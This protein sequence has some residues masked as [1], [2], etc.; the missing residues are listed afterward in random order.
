[1]AEIALVVHTLDAGGGIERV[2]GDLANAWVRRNHRVTAICLGGVDRA[3]AQLDERV[4][5][6]SLEVDAGYL[7]LVMASTAE[8]R[9]RRL[10]ASAGQLRRRT[11][12]VRESLEAIDPD[13]VVAFKTVDNVV[14]ALAS[15][16]LDAVLIACEHGSP[17]AMT[18]SIVTRLA[19]K[20]AFG[21]ADAV[22]ALT[23][24]TADWIRRETRASR[25]VVIPNSVDVD[26]F[27]GPV[28]PSC[29]DAG[30]RHL[31][32][33]GR[34]HPQKGFDLLLRAFGDV[35]AAHPAWNL[36][37]VGDGPEA[38]RLA[39]LIAA[40]GLEDRVSMPGWVADP[41]SWYRSADAFVLSSRW[42]GF[43]NVVL[44]AMA[45]GLSVVSYACP[46]GPADIIDHERTGLLVEP[47]SVDALAAGLDRLLG[48]A[49]LRE[50]LAANAR[51]AVGQYRVDAI[52]QRW[53]ALFHDLGV[54][55]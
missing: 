26:A 52:L 50:C 44:E 47:E 53:G 7:P 25:V 36:V 15:S 54:P 5:V 9:L 37:V 34:L 38:Q 8:G 32:A 41:R 1:M 43:G 23:G 3:A 11:V 45:S 24:A 19:R 46:D 2:A 21:R 16:R 18:E 42:E 49:S 48:D 4:A 10:A 55:V 40:L 31:L 51:E 35:A 29:D 27:A 22:V 28:D 17:S 30:P 33:V 12:A 39:S 14:A 6:R 13:V 20:H